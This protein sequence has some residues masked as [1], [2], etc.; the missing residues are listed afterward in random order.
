MTE[1]L[2]KHWQIQHI[3]TKRHEETR[4]VG[5]LFRQIEDVAQFRKNIDHWLTEGSVYAKMEDLRALRTKASEDGNL[6]VASNLDLIMNAGAKD[7]MELPQ[8]EQWNYELLCFIQDENRRA[9]ICRSLIYNSPEES[10]SYIGMSTRPPRPTTAQP[11]PRKSTPPSATEIPKNARV[12]RISEI[13]PTK[14]R[15]HSS[16]PPPPE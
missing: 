12:P 6:D 9:G 7:G 4:V 10:R 15:R 14:S 16:N 5:I 3:P 13:A 2:G 1:N 8:E 11:G